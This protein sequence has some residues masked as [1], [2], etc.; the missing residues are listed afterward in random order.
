MIWL[1]QSILT[2][3]F[4]ATAIMGNGVP[5]ES[6]NPF[7]IANS[8][9]YTVTGFAIEP[10][11]RS[12]PKTGQIV[13]ALAESWTFHA[14]EKTVRVKL[15]PG[16]VFHNGQTLTAED[17]KFTFDVHQTPE[18]EG[19]MRFMWEDVAAVKVIDSRTAEFKMKRWNYQAVEAALTSMRILPRTFYA[20]FNK[21]KFRTQIC[22]T[23]PFKL[24]SFDPNRSLEFEPNKNWRGGEAPDFNLLVKYIPSLSLA[25]QMHRKN[26]LDF[27]RPG[28]EVFRARDPVTRIKG[29]LGSGFMLGINLRHPVLQNKKVRR[30]LL[31]AWRREDLNKKIY[32]G[33]MK[34]ALDAFS[35][36]T[37]FYPAGDP[38]KFDLEKA[39]G[40][41]AND[42]WRDLDKDGVLE[43][44]KL[45]LEFTV[46][47]ATDEDERWASLLKADAAQVGIAMHIYRE[48][49]GP[50]FTKKIAEGQYDALATGG[51]LNNEVTALAWHSKAE[52][53]FG[54]YA[55]KEIDEITERLQSEFDLKKR[56]LILRKAIE[57]VRADLPQIP[58][59]FSEDEVLLVSKRLR[60]MPEHA[61]EP[62][63]WKLR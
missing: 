7:T 51:G 32:D 35:P 21:E 29:G 9:A 24:K 15:R 37:D 30:A 48:V 2:T 62:W 26:E 57:I 11:A 60:L 59:L 6:L 38:V 1:I 8:V 34:L 54:K 61:T 20:P 55:N 44:E 23:G 41:L 53:N 31:L 13:P 16:V 58:G 4:A 46:T 52:Y 27:Y 47:V 28:S 40:I 19:S 45:K 10:L 56:R 17:V 39:R 36:A 49:L 42:G 18:Y 33:S 25:V 3:A 50:A 22:G 12:N 5:I 63:T 43:K 14:P